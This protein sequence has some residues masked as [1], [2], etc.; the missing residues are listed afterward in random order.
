ML[1]WATTLDP[2]WNDLALK[3]VY[4]PFVHQLVRQVAGYRE[5]KSG[6]VVGS[7][8]LGLY[9]AEGHLQ[10]MGVCSSFTA[11]PD[12]NARATGSGA[13]ATPAIRSPTTR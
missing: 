1:V 11:V 9:D 6:P 5:H 3:P 7:L 2:M 8:L 4:L 10:H 13:R 12:A